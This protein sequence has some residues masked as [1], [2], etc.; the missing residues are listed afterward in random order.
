MAEND[1]PSD[2]LQELVDHLKEY[3]NASGVYIAKLI[4]P[5]KEIGDDANE[6]AH[7]D[8]EA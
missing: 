6:N 8:P 5:K 1:D 4:R 2:L 3:T 7:E